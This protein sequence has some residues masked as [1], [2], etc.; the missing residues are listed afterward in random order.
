MGRAGETAGITGICG[1][2]SLKYWRYG[3]VFFLFCVF[4]DIAGN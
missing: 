3:F 4:F 1:A 2:L